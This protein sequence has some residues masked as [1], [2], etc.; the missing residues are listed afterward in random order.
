MSESTATKVDSVEEAQAAMGRTRTPVSGNAEKTEAETTAAKPV[1]MPA[2]RASDVIDTGLWPELPQRNTDDFLDVDIVVEDFRILHSREYNNDYA[3]I[4]CYDA[5]GVDF[6]TVCGGSV[7]VEKLQ[8][9]KNSLPLTAAF[10]MVEPKRG[11][12]A[13][14]DIA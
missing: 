1:R 8:Q 7:V 14:M 9:M 2:R 3:V 4:K 5:D 6:T 13:Y 10:K 11:G 12:R